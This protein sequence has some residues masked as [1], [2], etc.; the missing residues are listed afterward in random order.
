MKRFRALLTVM[1]LVLVV[2]MPAAAVA[3]S[4]K[5]AGRPTFISHPYTKNSTLRIDKD[6]RTWGYVNTWK[7][8]PLTKDATVTI[9]VEKWNAS[10]RSWESSGGLATTAT[11]SASGKF[12]KKTNYFANMKIGITGRYRMRAM[13]VWMDTAGVEHTKWSSR[14]YF[15]MKK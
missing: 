12:K 9:A 3:K 15:K 2:A 14:K 11:V 13:L 8:A 4:V 10:A 7:R 5:A 1:V 6:F